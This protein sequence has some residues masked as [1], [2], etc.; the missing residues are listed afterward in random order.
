MYK[1]VPFIGSVNRDL[2]GRNRR[3]TNNFNIVNQHNRVGVD[4]ILPYTVQHTLASVFFAF[5]PG[6]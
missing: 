4:I 3:Q 2:W 5:L 1:S 6:F